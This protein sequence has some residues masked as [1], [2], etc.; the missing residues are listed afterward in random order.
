M[1]ESTYSRLDEVKWLKKQAEQQ[2]GEAINPIDVEGAKSD[3]IHL[4]AEQES[5]IK[6]IK[7]DLTAEV[8]WNKLYEA[9]RTRSRTTKAYD[10]TDQEVTILDIRR[11]SIHTSRKIKQQIKQHRRSSEQRD[12]TQIFDSHPKSV[13]DFKGID[14]PLNLNKSYS[15]MQSGSPFTGT[16][17]GVRST[18]R[19]TQSFA[20]PNDE[21]DK[22][23]H[24]HSD[25]NDPRTTKDNDEEDDAFTRFA[26]VLGDNLVVHRKIQERP[27]K[28]TR[29]KVYS[30]RPKDKIEDFEYDIRSTCASLQIVLDKEKI[31]Y[32]KRF[33]DGD[34]A[35]FASTLLRSGNHTMDEVF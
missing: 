12:W 13:D 14:S 7:S 20:A 22:D 34:A 5:L 35:D 15:A 17:K 24:D 23:A 9:E 27:P 18:T 19:Q 31:Q 6:D 10:S 28:C 26:Q 30:G 4:Q 2:I 3:K 1:W 32:M 16:S 25:Y 11:R 33:L 29:I 8:N 21:N